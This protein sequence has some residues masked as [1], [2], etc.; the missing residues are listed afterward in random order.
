M[1]WICCKSHLYMNDNIWKGLKYMNITTW[2]WR[3]NWSR[4]RITQNSLLVERFDKYI[5]QCVKHPCLN[6]HTRAHTHTLT[7]T[8]ARTHAH[9][10]THTHTHTHTY[11]YIYTYIIDHKLD[12]FL[13]DFVIFGSTL[14][15][16]IIT[17]HYYRSRINE[18]DKTFKINWYKV[19]MCVWSLYSHL[20][21]IQYISSRHI[22]NISLIYWPQ[23]IIFFSMPFAK[24]N[25]V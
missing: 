22:N 18:T 12:K 16:R 11:I 17:W 5:H 15:N 7:H 13:E 2:V 14:C 10:H 19:Y 23:L 4:R 3:D 1:N 21:S 9:A 6:T 20:L 24:L 8:H 25:L